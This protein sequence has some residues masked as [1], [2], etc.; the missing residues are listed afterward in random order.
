MQQAPTKWVLPLGLRCPHCSQ[1]GSSLYESAVGRCEWEQI[2]CSECGAFEIAEAIDEM[3]VTGDDD[4]FRLWAGSHAASYRA[5]CRKGEITLVNVSGVFER[6]RQTKWALVGGGAWLAAGVS[7]SYLP[8]GYLMVAVARG[9]SEP[10]SSSLPMLITAIGDRPGTPRLE[11]WRELILE[12]VVSSP[13]SRRLAPI[14]TVAAVDL[15]LEQLLG[16]EIGT[17][18][19]SRKLRELTKRLLGRRVRRGRPSSWNLHAEELTGRRLSRVPRLDYSKL[20]QAVAIRNDLA[21]GRELRIPAELAEAEAAWEER[22]DPSP[23]VGYPAPSST[24]C[25]RHCLSAVRAVR[26]ELRRGTRILG[27]DGFQDG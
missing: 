6:V 1:G 9:A 16:R 22:T 8:Q 10:P 14:L 26:R 20:K 15:F 5:E 3:F 11:P 19:P 24:F 7:V 25:L 27:P 4:G 21:H 13:K 2:E 23:D 18:S 17:D 12:A